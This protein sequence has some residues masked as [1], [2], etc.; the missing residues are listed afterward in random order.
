MG[1]VLIQEEGG[2]QQPIYYVS[3]VLKDAE[4]RYPS[5]EKF[6]YALVVASRKLRLYFQG[7]D[8]KVITNQPLRKILHKPDLS[9]RLLNWAVELSQ[10]NI[11]YEPRKAIKAQA[12]SDFIVE[13]SFGNQEHE[14]PQGHIM[15]AST[16]TLPAST[17]LPASG[18]GLPVPA[19]EVI[20]PASGEEL[21]LSASAGLL[22][23]SEELKPPTWKLFVDGS[24]TNLRSG[25]GVI[26][27]S[28]DGFQ[29]MQALRFA[30]KA[31]NNQVEYEALIAGLNLAR[32]LQVQNLSIF[33]DSQIVVRQTV[34][35]YATKDLVLAK[36]Q[37]IVQSLLS[38]ITNPTLVQVNREDN[39][40]A[41]LL[42]KLTDMDKEGLDGSVY[43]EELQLPSTEG[44]QIM[45]VSREDATCMTTVID[46]LKDGIL[47]DSK[48][49]AKQLQ[50][51]SAKYFIQNE[52]LSSKR[53]QGLC[54]KMLQ[55]P[56]IQQCAQ[57]SFSIAII[58]T[59]PHSFCNV[60]N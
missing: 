46:Y 40:I 52:T 29:I 25:A 41:D 44:H 36:Y 2:L 23:A 48:I 31:T 20:S 49:K 33:S 7:R 12:L 22:P 55:M 28:P 3:Q 53:L 59:I 56:T 43:F 4:T 34:G 60:G 26:L 24:S 11:E 9:G 17:G 37:T 32:S 38:S 50:A 1:A 45:E 21:P 58:H 39:T 30:F 54:Q 19:S 6:A 16:G 51:Q 14:F 42:S 13:C 8:I 35:E 18:E 57:A 15:P 47:P 5:V 10:F 27:I